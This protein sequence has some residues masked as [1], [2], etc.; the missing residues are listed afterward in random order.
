[1]LSAYP[2]FLTILPL[3]KAFNEHFVSCLDQISRETFELYW[4]EYFEIVVNHI[5]NLFKR[6]HLRIM[7]Q[8]LYIIHGF[9]RT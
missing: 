2:T 1:M 9:V 3:R 8:P 7:H 6:I 4:L 5:L